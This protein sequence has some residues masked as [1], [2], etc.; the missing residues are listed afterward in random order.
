[1][2]ALPSPR[3]VAALA[4]AAALLAACS[5]SG[6]GN[7]D[8]PSVATEIVIKDAVV[9]IGELRVKLLL[10]PAELEGLEQALGG[11][12]GAS[13]SGSGSGSGASSRSR[14]R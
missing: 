1:M 2:Q 9:T 6:R 5:P 3:A 7:L 13:G 12:G 10:T 8:L 4:L 11:Q 14:S